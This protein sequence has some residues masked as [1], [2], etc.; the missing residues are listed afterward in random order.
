MALQMKPDHY[1]FILFLAETGCRIGEARS[2]RWGDVAL[3][4]GTATVVRHKTGGRNEIELSPRLVEVLKAARPDIV[5]AG[6][7]C[8]P[9]RGE[10]AQ[11]RS[12]FRY[13]V[14]D[15]IIRA[16]LGR[17]RRVTPHMLRHTWASLHM[18]RQTPLKWIQQHGGWASAKMLL[19][20]YGHFMPSEQSGYAANLTPRGR[21][22]RV[23]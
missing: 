11:Q 2:L 21:A 3:E 22:K 19:D 9:N 10:N 14:W 15:P 23:V 17:T 7:Y 18:A 8:F 4:C 5:P 16:A 1:P 12:E 13:Q 6:T 20:T